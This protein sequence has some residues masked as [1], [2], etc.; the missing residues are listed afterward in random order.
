MHRRDA[1]R[2][3]AFIVI[4][5]ILGLATGAVALCLLFAAGAYIAM[6]HL[7]LNG[8]LRWVRDRKANEPPDTPGLI[9][10]LTLEFDSL[11]ERH[12]K[13]KKRL[14]N[15]LRQF[16][17][18]TRAL[19]D[20]TIVL[21]VN[22][23]VRWAN[24]AARRHLGIRWPEDVGQ[25]ITNLVRLPE[26]REF[27]EHEHDISAIEIE[28][29]TEHNRYLSVL[30]APYGKDQ[31]L[32]VARDVT[33]LHRANRIRSDFVANVSHELR[34]PITVFRGY[35]ENLIGQREQGPEKW[36]PALDQMRKHAERMS[37][38]VEELLL[39]SKL[40]QD[41]RV[42]NPETVHVGDLIADIHSRAREISGEREHLFSL[43]IEPGLSITGARTEVYS[44]FSNL[45]F[46]AVNYTPARGIIQIRWY[47]D[48]TG[49]H[50]AVEDNGIGIAD[51]QLPRLTERFYRVDGSRSRT[52][53][54]T[55]LGLA[56]VKHVL[57]RH[58]AQLAI[59][60]TLGKGSS[61][62]CDFPEDVIVDGSEAA[63]GGVRDTG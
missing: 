1:W 21:D 47:R 60:S 34:T 59:T 36:W 38:L 42:P 33:Q 43:E 26:L 8:L 11:R 19:P 52:E 55:G 62:R 27:V 15:Y 4:G 13:R 24:D 32:L 7:K 56:I 18:A 37:T 40:E 12:K 63:P 46:N 10:D 57:V 49:A 23:E 58:G 25:R 28:S 17:Q 61:F 6:L 39:L 2:L 20:A 53:G 14:A 51:D 50:F 35:L 31:R 9:E 5:F 41:S 45:V 30:I 44:A 54:G 22:D 29:Q 16:R 48:D 3:A